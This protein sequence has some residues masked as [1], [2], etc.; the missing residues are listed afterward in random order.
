MGKP[1]VG[2]TPALVV[3]IPKLFGLSKGDNTM[4]TIWPK[5]ELQRIAETD[6]L[7]ISPFR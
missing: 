2:K 7:H 5:D 1:A 3:L 4:T 6:G